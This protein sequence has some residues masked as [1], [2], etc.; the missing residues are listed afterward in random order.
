MTAVAIGPAE[1]STTRPRRAGFVSRA[2]ADGIDFVIVGLVFALVLVGIALTRFLVTSHP[3]E[4]P[5]PS[6]GISSTAEYLL[7]AA[8]LAWGWASTGRTPGKALLGLRVITTHG[9]RLTPARATARAAVCS[10]FPVV[11]AWV[12]VSRRNA[13][14]HDLLLR[15]TVVYDWRPR[16]KEFTPTG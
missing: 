3:F 1:V 14:I 12:L 15:T 10:L 5:R 2:S 11:L 16:A 7:L 8:Y 9:E 13:G 4:L 6:L